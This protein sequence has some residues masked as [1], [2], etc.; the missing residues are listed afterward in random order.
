VIEVP[1]LLG[2]RRTGQARHPSTLGGESI[3]APIV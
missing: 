1:E 3:G 2:H